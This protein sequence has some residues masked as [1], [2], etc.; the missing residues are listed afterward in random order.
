[1]VFGK[2]GSFGNSGEVG[3]GFAQAKDSIDCT[4]DG[5]G[6][7]AG[8]VHADATVAGDA[9]ALI[10]VICR[11]F[12]IE[13]DG[14]DARCHEIGLYGAGL[15]RIQ[16]LQEGEG[17]GKFNQALLGVFTVAVGGQRQA[18]PGSVCSAI[19]G[20]SSDNRMKVGM[21]GWLA[22]NKKPLLPRVL[23]ADG[24]FVTV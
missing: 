9:A 14:C 10:A 11:P 16:N 23:K 24:I 13:V 5:T 1:L 21:H 15:V 18:K 8:E 4:G 2:Y 17:G 22:A 20:D 19:F 6:I 12:G 3:D 7:E